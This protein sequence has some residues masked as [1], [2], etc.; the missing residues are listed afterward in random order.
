MW[1][2]RVCHRFDKTQVWTCFVSKEDRVPWRRESGRKLILSRFTSLFITYN[3]DDQIWIK[4][5]LTSN[6]VMGLNYQ[7]F[8]EPQNTTLLY[9]TND[10]PNRQ[11]KGLI[12]FCFSIGTE[13][14]VRLFGRCEVIIVAIQMHGK[15]GIG[16]KK[17]W[18]DWK[19]TSL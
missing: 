8:N 9:N 15:D 19:T 14:C 1:V 3:W 7:E 6:L 10:I 12:I 5:R 13:H 2:H 11:I 4:K 17:T 18:L 16:H